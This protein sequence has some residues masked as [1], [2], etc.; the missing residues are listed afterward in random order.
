M[1]NEE[2][3]FQK[4]SINWFPGHMAK[5]RRQIKENIS[6]VDIIYEVVDARIPKSSK[7]KDINELVKDKPRILIMTKG[8]LCD[9]NK[10]NEWARKYEKEGY[11]VVLV[12]LINNKGTDKVIKVTNE[13]LADLNKKR[14]DFIHFFYDTIWI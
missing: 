9:L 10:T 11:K 2:K 8:D 7:I 12:D 13:V 6:M 1:A 14:V 4:S 5:A 3:S